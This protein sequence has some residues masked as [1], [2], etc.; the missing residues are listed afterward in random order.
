MEDAHVSLVGEASSPTR[1]FLIIY[2]FVFSW[3]LYL[4]V[5]SDILVVDDDV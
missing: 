2:K 1:Y 4:A 3:D 5:V